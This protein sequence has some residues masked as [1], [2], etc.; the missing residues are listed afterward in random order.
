MRFSSLRFVV[1]TGLLVTLLAGCA[2]YHYGV[3]EDHW[4]RMSESER[5]EVIRIYQERR[6]HEERRRAVEAEMRAH[7]M[8]ARRARYPETIYLNLSGGAFIIKGQRYAFHQHAFKLRQGETRTFSL[9][10]RNGQSPH[11]IKIWVR[12]QDGEVMLGDGKRY[13]RTFK[14]RDDWHKGDH[15]KGIKFRG[16][17]HIDNVDLFIGPEPFRHNQ[18]EDNYQ[19][20]SQQENGRPL[21]RYEVEVLKRQR[22]KEERVKQ[23]RAN[24][25]RAKQERANQERAK[26]ERA[27]QERAKQER[28]KQE[29][30][31]QERAKQE[32][33]KQERAKQERAK[34]ERAKQERAKQERAKQQR[35]KQ[36]QA[37]QEQAKQER[38]KQEQTKLLKE[39]QEK[40]EKEKKES[41][42]NKAECIEHGKSNG[43]SKNGLPYCDE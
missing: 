28:A 3:R 39:K 10:S 20:R 5:T 24:Q 1:L 17:V 16:N 43:R 22:A 29:R 21:R 38:T 6:L 31:K 26:Q 19:G 7:E 2:R 35:A 14:Y 8:A 12:Y 33:A 9:V 30:A 32:R 41:N 27:K 37:K 11:K 15:Y 23:E 25:E 40:E 42:G 13:L 36:E 4:Q 18:T 34:Q